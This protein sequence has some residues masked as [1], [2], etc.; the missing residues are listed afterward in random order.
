M[1]RWGEWE[2]GRWG[3]WERGSIFL[4]PFDCQLSTINC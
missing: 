2:M 4:I 1:G 3:E